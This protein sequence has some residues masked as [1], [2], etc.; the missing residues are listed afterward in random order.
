MGAKN[1]TDYED[2]TPVNRFIVQSNP[3]FNTIIYVECILKVIAM[4]FYFG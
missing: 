4:G 1:Y 2:I 3:I